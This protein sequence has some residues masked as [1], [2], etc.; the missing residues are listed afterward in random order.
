MTSRRSGPALSR[1]VRLAS[2]DNAL[3]LL[4]MG[5]YY[6][7]AHAMML[8]IPEAWEKHTLMDENRRAFYEYHAAMMEPWDGPAAVAFTDGR[9]IGATLDRNGLRPARYL[10]TD[11]D[12]VV[13]A[14][15]SGVLPIPEKKIVKKWR[16]QPGKMFLIDMEQGRIIDDKE[17]KDAWPM[18][19]PIASG[20]RRSASSSTKC[21]LRT[22]RRHRRR[23]LSWIASRPSATPRKT[24]RS[25]W[26]PWCRTVRKPPAPWG[27][28]LHCLSSPSRSK[29]LYA[30]FKQLFAQ[31]T[32]PPIDPIREDLVMSLVSFVGPKPNLLNTTD[33]NPPI[34]L[35]VSQPVLSSSDMEKLR[36]IQ[37]YTGGKF[38][39][40]ELDICYPVAWGQAGVEARLACWPRTPR[41]PSV[42]GR[43]SSLFPTAR[44]TPIG[45][46][47]G[48]ARHLRNPPA[49]REEGLAH[50]YR[51]WWWRL[52]PR[53]S[54]SF[55][56]AGRLRCRSGPS[57]P[58]PGDHRGLRQGRR[59]KGRQIRQELR[60][61]GRQG[62]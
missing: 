37:K 50:Q 62:A 8:M 27:P 33:I 54:T 47:S 14:S 61:G 36:H 38:R 28:T 34:R 52:G 35:E 31:V 11:D 49:S 58:R 59:R 22:K 26:S 40:F 42:R 29:T 4:V 24:L 5:G 6:S 60:Q 53:G 9:Q 18:P 7:L 46:H 21:P 16:L 45:R 10:V 12:L 39:S 23:P 19:N 51:A 30:Y 25:S 57:L 32:N 2:F 48:P 43:T 56:A 41:M 13:M 20:S 17:L 15:E 44:S 3:E 55:R 1:P